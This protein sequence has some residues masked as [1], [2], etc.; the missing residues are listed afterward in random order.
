M[1]MISNGVYYNSVEKEVPNNG[2]RNSE[3]VQ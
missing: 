2:S 3:V 1:I